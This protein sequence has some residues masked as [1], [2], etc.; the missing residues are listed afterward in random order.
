MTGQNIVVDGG[1]TLHGSGVDGIFDLIFPAGG[2]AGRRGGGCAQVVGRRVVYGFGVATPMVGSVPAW[3]QRD[4]SN[5]A[6]YTMV[7]RVSKATS[8]TG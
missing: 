3:P 5:R 6:R 1:L 8:S 4:A 7:V 2:R